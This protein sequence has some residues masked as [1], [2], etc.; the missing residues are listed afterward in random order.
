MLRPPLPRSS[1]HSPPSIAEASSR[2][3]QY[4]CSPWL[5]ALPRS[6]LGDLCSERC[7]FQRT[8]VVAFSGISRTIRTIHPQFH[9]HHGPLSPNIT[10]VRASHER[11]C[12]PGQ[13][14]MCCWKWIRPSLT[15]INTATSRSSPRNISLTWPKKS[16]A[17]FANPNTSTH[18]DRSHAE[19]LGASFCCGPG[20]TQKHR[21]ASCDGST[22]LTGHHGASAQ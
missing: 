20:S 16:L 13:V 22:P 6:S 11:S 19:D 7:R 5:Q 8:L 14:K 9:P 2:L 18:C 4:L 3:A 21:G 15:S 10:F 1:A 17:P 12:R